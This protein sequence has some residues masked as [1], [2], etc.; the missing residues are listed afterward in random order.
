[1]ENMNN[2]QQEAELILI[3][4]DINS[5]INESK[6][7]NRLLENDINYIVKRNKIDSI[8]LDKD[9]AKSNIEMF[10]SRKKARLNGKKHEMYN[11]AS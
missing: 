1:M 2:T 10:R 5:I 9:Q 6:V 7:N 8:L 4:S 3:N 11:S